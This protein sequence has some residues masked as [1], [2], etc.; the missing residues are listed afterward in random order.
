MIIKASSRGQSES[1][2]AILARHLLSND[3]ESV[4][5]LELRGVVATDLPGAIEEARL[6]GAKGS[7]AYKILYH[8]SIN[9]DRDEAPSLT[10][11]HWLAA[12]DELQAHLGMSSEHQRMVVLHQKKG[13]THAHIVFSRINPGTMK[14]VSDSNNYLAH[15]RCSRKLE[16]LWQLKPVVGPLTRPK[17]TP[18]P[19]KM[20]ASHNDQQ[21]AAR[22]ETPVADVAALIRKSWDATTTGHAFAAAIEADGLCLARGRRGIVIL[23]R[24]TLVP[25]GIARRL[26]RPATEIHKR[27]SDINPSMLPT[28][29]QCQQAV[30]GKTKSPNDRR[31]TMSK[32]SFG[33]QSGRRLKP[34]TPLREEHRDYWV[35]LEFAVEQSPE[36]WRVKLSPISTLIDAGDVLTLHRTGS[37]DPTDEEI[38]AMIVAGKNRGWTSIRFFGGSESFQLR[39]RVLAAKGGYFSW[40]DISLECEEGRPKPLAAKMPQHVRDKLMPPKPETPSVPEPP[41]NDP[42]PPAPEYRP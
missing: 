18:R 33:C 40:D 22:T 17:G 15:E 39:A 10:R 25:H 34:L 38:L 14:T 32:K 31:N 13:R 37:S 36:G 16:K 11:A 6:A 35:A 42:Q 5:I 19:V 21:A 30:R 23:D 7:R 20:G 9:L 26:A 24:R 12:A 2:A 3:N 41:T 4:E 1:D 29:E 8:A 27:L 28:V